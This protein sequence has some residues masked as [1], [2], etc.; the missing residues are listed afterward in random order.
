MERPKIT[1]DAPDGSDQEPVVGP[2]IPVYKIVEGV[3]LDAFKLLCVS[4]VNAFVGWIVTWEIVDT[5]QRFTR[6]TPTEP[7]VKQG[8]TYIGEI[9]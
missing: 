4:V 5:K 8:N 6:V 9:R 2:I 3:A 7:N 1:T